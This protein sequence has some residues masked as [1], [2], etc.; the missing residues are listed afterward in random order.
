[1]V[2]CR[3]KV[4][5]D[6]LADVDKIVRAVENALNGAALSAKA[7]FGVV[8]QTWKTKPTFTIEKEPGYRAI[9]TDDPIFKFVDEGT[10]IRYAHF[11]PDFR[12][13]THPRAIGSGGGAG[14]MLFL[15]LTDPMPGIEARE[16]SDTIEEKWDTE[17]PEILQRAIDSVVE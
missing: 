10:A 13:K 4:P 9:M 7:D 3:V 11:G 8:T 1:M 12:P 14:K 5:K 16:F 2:R 15:S 17:L 6:F